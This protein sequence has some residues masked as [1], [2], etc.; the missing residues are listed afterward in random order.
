MSEL[1]KQ[2]N[3]YPIDYPFETLNGRIANNKLKLDVDDIVNFRVARLNEIVKS[4]VLNA[5]IFFFISVI[6][7]LDE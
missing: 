5:S 1:T 3:L 7:S 6:K 4:N 2:L